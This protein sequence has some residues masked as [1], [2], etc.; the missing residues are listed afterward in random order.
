MTTLTSVRGMEPWR[1]RLYLPA[2]RVSDA[3]RYA[4]ISPQTVANWHYRQ[5][6]LG[7]AL[8]GREQRRPL[9]YLQLVEVAIV[10]VFRK[11]GVPLNSIRRTREY[12]AQNFESEYPFAEYKFK[13]D[14]YHL[15][16]DLLQFE[17][18]WDFHKLIVADKGGQLGWER[19][20]EDKLYEFDYEYDLAIRWHVAGRQSPVIID[21]RIA[22][23][24]PT[25]EGIPTWALKGRWKAGESIE[26]I[27]VD[28]RLTQEGV[29]YALE[30]ED[31][32][33]V[34]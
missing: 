11:F 23:G 6:T 33:V 4:G 10:A 26:D 12:M 2:Y 14:G 30:F 24:A 29:K 5:A 28:F 22:F 1:R 13:T 7:P 8:P 21:P 25:I 18:T 27:E 20:M 15:L 32:R 34:S 3:A 17:P 9:S 19:M 31:I 16:M